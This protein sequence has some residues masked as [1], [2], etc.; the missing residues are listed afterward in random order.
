MF[1]A[2]QSPEPARHWFAAQVWGG[3]EQ[4]CA[5][6]LSARG[7][8]VFFPS[9]R[10]HRRWSDRI[11]TIDRAVF[12]G[13]LFCRLSD[14]VFAKVVTTPGVIRIV[15][16]GTRPLPVAT[17]EIEALQRVMERRLAAEPWEFLRAGERVRIHRGPLAGLE[18]IVLRTSARHRLILSV[19]LLQRA[20]SVEIDP[21]WVDASP[22][23]WLDTSHTPLNQRACR[24]VR[25]AH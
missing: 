10:E 21:S 17:E 22:R 11:K 15:G 2:P 20:V 14:E 3:R 6:H 8:D 18:G 7:Y 9:Y 23:E 1:D 19:S 24:S 12:E 4:L 5:T 13:Y 16:D 25:W